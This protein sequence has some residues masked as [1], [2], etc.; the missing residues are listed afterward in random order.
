MENDRVAAAGIYDS[1]RHRR[2]FLDLPNGLHWPVVGAETATGSL[3][4]PAF[5]IGRI[6]LSTSN[7]LSRLAINLECGGDRSRRDQHSSRHAARKFYADLFSRG[8]FLL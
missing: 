7:E 1:Q 4:S 8:R 2:V 6:L 5:P 3:Q